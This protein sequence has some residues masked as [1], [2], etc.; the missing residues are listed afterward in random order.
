AAWRVERRV[1]KTPIGTLAIGGLVQ[2]RNDTTRCRGV[3]PM[4]FGSDDE[5]EQGYGLSGGEGRGSD[6]DDV[7]QGDEHPIRPDHHLKC[8]NSRQFE[9][10]QIL[11]EN[12]QEV[13]QCPSPSFTA[14][15]Q[16][17]RSLTLSAPLH[18]WND[19]FHGQKLVPSQDDIEEIHL[20]RREADG[21]I[22]WIPER[23]GKSISLD[24]KAT[25][26]EYGDANA[27]W[28]AQ[29]TAFRRLV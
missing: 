25:P 24:L 12:R 16:G 27:R 14:T 19:H 5:E 11:E 13:H 7:S 6:V 3:V 4:S 22:P 29:T 15:G 20:R 2:A 23:S 28:I 10:V 21:P 8:A 9:N 1:K 18:T 17:R 26:K